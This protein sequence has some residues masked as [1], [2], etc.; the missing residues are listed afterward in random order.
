MELLREISESDIG[1]P[2]GEKKDI[3]YKLRKAAR[4]LVFNREGKIAILFVSKKNYHKLPGGGIEDGEDVKP[5][6][7]REIMEE[8]GCSVEIR[9]RDVGMTIE[10]RDGDGLLQISYCYLSDVVGT[11]AA[12]AFTEREVTNGFQLKWL[13]MDEAISVLKNDAPAESFEKFMRERDLTFL[14]KAKE[15]ISRQA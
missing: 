8:T 1:A 3:R 7:A 9:T 12:T 14:Q 11:P 5:A 6:L 15:M 4:A 13:G 2:L 10:Y